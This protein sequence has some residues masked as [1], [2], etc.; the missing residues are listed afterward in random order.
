MFHDNDKILFRSYFAQEKTWIFLRSE[1]LQQSR[2]KIFQ[3]CS[4][5]VCQS[6]EEINRLRRF[7]TSLDVDK[8]SR[9]N[10]AATTEKVKPVRH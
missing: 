10:A 3:A 6:L 1:I 7:A 9:W 4:I 8:G 5:N 2:R